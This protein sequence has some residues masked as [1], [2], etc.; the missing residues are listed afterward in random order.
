MT[1]RLA[2]YLAVTFGLS[3]GLWIPLGFAFE[4][5]TY[6]ENSAPFIIAATS[7]VMFFPLVGAVVAEL[8][9]MG[10]L[11]PGQSRWRELANRLAFY[12]RIGG[13][14]PN[15]LLAWFVPAGL[16]LLGCVV[17]FLAFPHEFD[18]SMGYIVDLVAQTGGSA[19]E[20][21]LPPAVLVAVTL[22]QALTWAPFFNMF[23]AFGEE[24][25][26]RGLLFPELCTRLS[27]RGA[28]FV[29]GIIWGLWHAPIIAMGHNYGMDYAGFPVLGIVVMTL[30]CAAYGVWL[31]WL[32]LRSQSV[33]PCALNHGA[34][35]A[36]AGM[37]LYF[38]A[39]GP[40][41][42]GPSPLGLVA[43]IPLFALGAICWLK[44]SSVRPSA[45][46]LG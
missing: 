11:A 5:F 36:I 20:L 6:G 32:R 37:G 29:S 16:A 41:V 31:A 14:I 46:S 26:W 42:F 15:Y 1:K 2:I 22:F 27:H 8:A 35:N 30:A 24:A 28:A 7:I 12:P 4:I 3:W 25:G 39:T 34:F 43:G 18:T 9:C 17:Y 19:Q 40:N 33:W 21:P 45:R 38:S 10:K 44:L 23:F 13:N